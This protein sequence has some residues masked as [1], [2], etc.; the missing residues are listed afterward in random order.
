MNSYIL[1]LGI[2]SNWIDILSIKH[3]KIVFNNIV[4]YIFSG[5][6]IIQVA[7]FSLLA[8][9]ELNMISNYLSNKA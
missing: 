2:R 3:M 8:H 6:K 1:A 4:V 5:K 9:T 7:I